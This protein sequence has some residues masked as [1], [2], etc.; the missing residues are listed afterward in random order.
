MKETCTITDSDNKE[1]KVEV[2]YHFECPEKI[3][4][5]YEYPIY[6]DDEE[7]SYIVIDDVIGD[8]PSDYKE[9]EE[10]Y[11]NEIKEQLSN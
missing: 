7:N 4:D 10:D 3:V 5:G 1:I 9:Y 6:V 2:V 8:L 11:K